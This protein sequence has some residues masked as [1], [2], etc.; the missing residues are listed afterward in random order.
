MVLCYTDVEQLSPP[1]SPQAGERDSKGSPPCS[2]SRS[3]ADGY[4]D[5]FVEVLQYLVD[6]EGFF[7]GEGICG[8]LINHT[9]NAIDRMGHDIG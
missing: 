5:G 8:R 4:K 7:A 6:V 2:T 1:D 9:Q 3:Y